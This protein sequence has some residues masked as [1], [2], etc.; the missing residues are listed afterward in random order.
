[1]TDLDAETL[2]RPFEIVV[3]SSVSSHYSNKHII[4]ELIMLSFEESW[5]FFPKILNFV[6]NVR[7]FFYVKSLTTLTKYAAFFYQLHTIDVAFL[8]ML[9]FFCFFCLKT[10]FVT[11]LFH[12][13]YILLVL[14]EE[15]SALSAMFI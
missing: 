15:K 8:S 3:C 2:K 5:K 10:K 7:Q 13:A 4:R 6:K 1:M 14:F 11:I 12:S 9:F